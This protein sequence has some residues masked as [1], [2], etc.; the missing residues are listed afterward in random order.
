MSPVHS[1]F[2]STRRVLARRPWIQWLAIVVIA[3]A[4]TALVHARL[5]QVDRQRDSWG[6]T[7]TV[8]VASAPVE[9]G[10]P[11]LV[12]SRDLPA[13]M[14]PDGAIDPDEA[15]AGAPIARQRVGVGEIVTRLDVVADTG[16]QAMT[17]EGWLAVPVVESPRSGAVIGDR[18]QVASDG[19]VLS[20]DALV[21]GQFDDVTVLAVPAAE[22]PLLPAAAAAGA[23]T[24]LL[25]P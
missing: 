23:L 7:R 1:I 21:V 13:A 8:L 16:A 17:P 18:V 24:L 5:Q 10:E 3:A 12:E 25:K 14:I 2:V 20:A 22:A 15:R 9:I 19:W 11:L 4:V 6:S